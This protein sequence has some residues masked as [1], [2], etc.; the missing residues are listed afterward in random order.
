VQIL[1]QGRSSFLIIGLTFGKHIFSFPKLTEMRKCLFYFLPFLLFCLYLSFTASAQLQKIY[2][3]PK[4][5]ASEKQSQI[6]DS[7]RFIP[8]EVKEGID[9]SRYNYITVAPGHFLITD[10]SEKIVLL[11]SKAGSFVAKISY[12]K[13]GESVDAEYDEHNNRLVFFGDNKNY[14][15]TPKDRIKIQLDWSNP[16]NKKYFTK[17]IIDLSDTTFS[18]RK[19]DPDENDILRANHYYNNL[20]WRGQITTSPLYKDSLDYELKI[21]EGNRMVK[22]FF[23]YNRISEP[24]FLFGEESVTLSTTVLP[25]NRFVSR[26]YCDTIYKLS[27]GSLAPAY[28]LVMPLENAL[29]SSFY[30]KPFKN[31]TERENFRRNN[32]WMLRQVYGFYETPQYIYFSVG[33]LSN[34]ETYLYQKQTQTCYKTKNIRT[35]SSQYNLTLLGDYG[36]QR[37]GDRFYKP[38]KAGD[39]LAFFA[40]HKG[41]VPPKELESYLNSKPNTD[42]PVIVEFKFKN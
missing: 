22:G 14:A 12:K 9:L 33:Y 1:H 2:V 11:Y 19:T 31:K 8:L 18:F 36:V 20:Y 3:H 39:L 24:R 17:Y 41:V 16:R 30:T 5:A 23:P 28:Q 4:S 10:Y 21:Y 13:L 6:I 37:N 25:E 15:L 34:Y 32:G 40:K 29:P 26:P 38:Q 42:S 35:D 27:A 7:I